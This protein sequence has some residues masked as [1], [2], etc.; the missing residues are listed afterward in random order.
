[1]PS[2]VR[3]RGE[4]QEGTVV[5][6]TCTHKGSVIQ[7]LQV[8]LSL[9]PHSAPPCPQL[10]STYAPCSCCGFCYGRDPCCNHHHHRPLLLLHAPCCCNHHH[11]PC[12][13]RHCGFC[14][15]C[16]RHGLCL[17][18]C[19]CQRCVGGQG[20][21]PCPCCRHDGAAG[22]AAWG[23][24]QGAAA[25][26]VRGRDAAAG[27]LVRQESGS[28]SGS[29]GGACGRGCLRCRRCCQ[30]LKKRTS[31]CRCHCRCC[32]RCG[33]AC[34]A[35][36]CWLFC[37]CCASS[38]SCA[39]CCCC[40]PSC[41]ASC[42]SSSCLLRTFLSACVLALL[43][44]QRGPSGR[45]A[46]TESATPPWWCVG[47]H[48][49][50]THR[51]GVCR[52]A[53]PT[54]GQTTK[55]GTANTLPS[56]LNSPRGWERQQGA[57]I[58]RVAPPYLAFLASSFFCNLSNTVFSKSDRVSADTSNLGGSSPRLGGILVSC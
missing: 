1:M 40:S 53:A 15:D 29:C 18:S 19:S 12:P 49:P 20:S 5:A 44:A 31:R 8:R 32:R 25:V 36:S 38:P 17:C 45:L 39:S 58:D 43:R 24:C 22:A 34:G 42:A 11:R 23:R 4:E 57:Q 21:D 52:Y 54:T 46:P 7:H 41:G 55:H 48:H 50:T 3:V 13:C 51:T 9:N 37:G 28:G 16:V 56:Q 30:N 2:A 27:V 26:V 14:Y 35:A 47:C 33:G 10:L 6:A